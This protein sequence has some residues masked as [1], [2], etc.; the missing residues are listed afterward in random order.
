MQSIA[1]Y[2]LAMALDT[3]LKSKRPMGRS[4]EL[5]D[6]LCLLVARPAETVVEARFPHLSSSGKE[7]LI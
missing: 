1:R 5:C 3:Y 4:R 7:R 2:R 6:A